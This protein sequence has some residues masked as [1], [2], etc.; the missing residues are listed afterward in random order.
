MEFWVSF[1]KDLLRW[2]QQSNQQAANFP[3]T[4]DGYWSWAMDS[5]GKLEVKYK[6]HPLVVKIL[7]AVLEYQDENFRKESDQHGK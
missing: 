5:L 3:I 2:M 4:T 7:T 6:R 1:F